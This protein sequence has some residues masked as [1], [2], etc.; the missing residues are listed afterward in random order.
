MVHSISEGSLAWASSQPSPGASSMCV[1]AWA[2]VYLLV[3][4]REFDQV[5]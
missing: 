2:S 4:E 3:N 5:S 1:L